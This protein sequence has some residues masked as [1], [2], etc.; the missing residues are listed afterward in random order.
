V[1][2]GTLV[3]VAPGRRLDTAVAVGVDAEI[4]VAV[5]VS[6]GVRV[7][8]LFCGVRAGVALGTVVGV[9]S[10]SVG[11]TMGGCGVLLA[12]M[13]VAL[14]CSV[15]LAAMDVALGC[16][17]ADAGASATGAL[18]GALVGALMDARGISVFVAVGG[19]AGALRVGLL[20]RVGGTRVIVGLIA[21]VGVMILVDVSVAIAVAV[22]IGGMMCGVPL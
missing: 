20:V 1:A 18:A 10:G 8:R 13:D 14:A 12:A 16:G 17:V 5:V 11:T 3:G 9:V 7:G 21:S 4:A 22:N 19:E 2:L 15:L 6:C